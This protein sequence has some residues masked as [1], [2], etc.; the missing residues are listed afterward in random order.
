MP[1]NTFEHPQHGTFASPE[2]VVASDQFSNTEKRTILDEWR[3]SLRH[4]LLDDPDAPQ[5]KETSERLDRAHATLGS[6]R[7]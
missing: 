1:M 7:K 6:S 3:D 4:I 2:D 5:V